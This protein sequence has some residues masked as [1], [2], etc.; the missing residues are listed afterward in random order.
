MLAISRNFVVETNKKRWY[1]N[2]IKNCPPEILPI[3]EDNFSIFY[4]LSLIIDKTKIKSNIIRIKLDNI[5]I[6]L[7]IIRIKSDNIWI[8]SDNILIKSDNILIKS[9]NILITTLIILMISE[10]KKILSQINSLR[11]DKKKKITTPYRSE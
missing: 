8:K 4:I 6:K 7:D 9:D 5:S 1:C 11:K 10:K 2:K 3:T